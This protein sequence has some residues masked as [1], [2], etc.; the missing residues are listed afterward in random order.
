M[1][2]AKGNREKVYRCTGIAIPATDLISAALF[3]KFISAIF[4][5]LNARS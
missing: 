2:N 3:A 5:T 1:Q 4:T